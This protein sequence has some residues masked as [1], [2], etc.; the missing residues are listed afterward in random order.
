MNNFIFKIEKEIFGNGERKFIGPA[1]ISD[2]GKC[3]F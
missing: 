1:V 3:S 2:S